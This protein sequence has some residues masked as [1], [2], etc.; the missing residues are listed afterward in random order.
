MD[1]EVWNILLILYYY[2]HKLIY[3][4]A[5]GRIA[6]YYDSE[7]LLFTGVVSS[8]G[9]AAAISASY[10][11]G[12]GISYKPLCCLSIS[13]ALQGTLFFQNSLGYRK[14]VVS[15]NGRSLGSTTTS[16]TS[17]TSGM[18]FLVEN[19][20]F[21]YS[22]D[23]VNLLGNGYLAVSPSGVGTSNASIFYFYFVFIF[24]FFFF[25]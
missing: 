21:E 17:S 13:N 6:I 12:P 22:F 16:V 3:V 5:G 9:G 15:N 1:W 19:T 20:R 2:I 24:V 25:F 4:G 18:A 11:G 8:Y 14:L 7:S 23:E 10:S